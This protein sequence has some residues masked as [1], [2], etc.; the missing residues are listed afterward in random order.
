VDVSQHRDPHEYL[1]RFR[2]DIAA[3]HTSR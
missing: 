3:R 2:L 1:F